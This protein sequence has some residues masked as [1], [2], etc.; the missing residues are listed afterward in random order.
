MTTYFLV[1]LLYMFT[2]KE[3]LLYHYFWCG[4]S[5]IVSGLLVAIKQLNPEF[6]I[7][8]FVFHLRAKVIRFDLECDFVI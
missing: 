2:G 1:I 4:F 7:P 3:S 5:G 6:G 8:L